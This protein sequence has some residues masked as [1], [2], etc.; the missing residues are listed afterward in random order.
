MADAQDSGILITM[1]GQASTPLQRAA[2]ILEIIAA[3]PEGLSLSDV[4]ERVG[5]PMPSAL[6]LL[7]NLVDIG[8]VAT[9]GRRARYRLGGRLQRMFQMSISTERLRSICE[10]EIQALADRLDLTAYLARYA[11]E[12][13]DLC[14]AFMPRE[15]ARTSVH[16]GQNFPINATA[17]GRILFAHQPDDVIARA[18]AQPMRKFRPRTPTKPADVRRALTEARAQGYALC[19]DELDEAT[20]AVA[21]PIETGDAGVVFSLG[22]LGLRDAF[23]ETLSIANAV[24]L[25]KEIAGRLGPQL[26][27]LGNGRA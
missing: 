10:P 12:R 5:L 17:V 1:P 25:L 24:A 26:A 21:V 14:C 13:V 3:A 6:R 27:S 9:E 18:I 4:A 22:L 16:P 2:R 19:D 7:R 8:F 15:P 23:V 11:D 20:L